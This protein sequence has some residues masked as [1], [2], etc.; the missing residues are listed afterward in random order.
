MKRSKTSKAWMQEHV[1][2]PYVQR[3]KA[4]GYRSRAAFKLM[5]VDARD[6]LLRPGMVVVDLGAAPGSWCQVVAGRVGAK[7]R[8]LALDLLEMAP[9]PGVDFLQGDFL[10]DAL[11]ARF[12]A[13]LEGRRVDLVLSDMAPNMSGIGSADQ[14]RAMGLCELALD[15][16]RRHLAPG[17]GFL[18]KTFQ[19]SGFTEFRA[20]MQADFRSIVV[21]KPDASRDRSAE[22]YLLGMG[23]KGAS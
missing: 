11:V 17:G 5:E 19:G 14:A 1:H 7:G 13:R 15:F 2:D 16:A 9:I 23:F 4:E 18:V 22:V 8:I 21:R 6:R 12:E 3:A 20:A 10:D